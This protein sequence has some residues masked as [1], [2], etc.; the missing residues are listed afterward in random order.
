M[1]SEGMKMMCLWRKLRCVYNRVCI[2][3]CKEVPGRKVDRA[4]MK[5]EG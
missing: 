3:G 5:E 1:C 4:I 2:I